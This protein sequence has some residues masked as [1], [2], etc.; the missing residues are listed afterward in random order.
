M[1]LHIICDTVFPEDWEDVVLE[2]NWSGIYPDAVGYLPNTTLK[3]IWG[4]Y[5][6]A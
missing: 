6:G 4:Y 5:V 3:I 1:K 2:L